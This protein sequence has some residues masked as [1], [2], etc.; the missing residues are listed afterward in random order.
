MAWCNSQAGLFGQHLFE[1]GKKI[2]VT[3]GEIDAMTVYQANGGYPVVSLN[4]G[5]GNVVKN[6]KHNLEWLCGFGRNY[7]YV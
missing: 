2:T 4:G 5:T 6:I 3:E 7:Y 1:G